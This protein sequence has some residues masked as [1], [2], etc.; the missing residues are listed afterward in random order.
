MLVSLGGTAEA[1]PT[2]TGG[3]NFANLIQVD[4]NNLGTATSVTFV[5][6]IVFGPQSGSFSGIPPLTPA[7]FKPLSLV[8]FA[9]LVDFWT[10]TY[11][12]LTYHFDLLTLAVTEQTSKFL[13]L[14][15]TGTMYV[16]DG[17]NNI[18]YAETNSAFA[19]SSQNPSGGNAGAFSASSTAE[20][21]PEPG[22]LLLI[23][24]GLA[25]LALRRRRKA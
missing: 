19:L 6:S 11:G 12:G 10:V 7:V 13:G 20:A 23:G 25:G 18:V 2:L 15:G 4:T 3:I 14:F 9:P 22:T 5:S 21:V 17:S 24:S 16:T 1:V 8:A